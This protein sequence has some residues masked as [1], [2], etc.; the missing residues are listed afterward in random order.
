MQVEAWLA[1]LASLWL[2]EDNCP[3]QPEQGQERRRKSLKPTWL[4]SM[5]SSSRT[6]MADSRGLGSAPFKKPSW[7]TDL[8]SDRF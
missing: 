4:V 1:R 7:I 5:D 2:D 8:H 3:G 6:N